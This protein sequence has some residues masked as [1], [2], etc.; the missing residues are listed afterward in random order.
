MLFFELHFQT[1]R[2][3][4][5]TL[6]AVVPG[7]RD[8]RRLQRYRWSALPLPHAGAAEVKNGGTVGDVCILLKASKQAS[9]QASHQKHW[10]RLWPAQSHSGGVC[11]CVCRHTS[12][13]LAPNRHWQQDERCRR[14]QPRPLIHGRALRVITLVAPV[15]SAKAWAH[16]NVCVRHQGDRPGPP[17]AP[18]GGG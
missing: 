17:R 14:L 7:K 9:K 4:L 16:H 8:L 3:T 15:A 13:T 11:V 2:H 6:V 10:A 1:N 18:G 12:L 5:W